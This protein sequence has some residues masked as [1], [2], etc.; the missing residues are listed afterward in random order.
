MQNEK[1]TQNLTNNFRFTWRTQKFLRLSFNFIFCRRRRL[2][3]TRILFSSLNLKMG[4]LSTSITSIRKKKLYCS[5]LILHHVQLFTVCIFL[6]TAIK[7]KTSTTYDIYWWKRPCP[8]FSILN[9][10]NWKNTT[11]TKV[12]IV[13]R[14]NMTYICRCAQNYVLWILR[15]FQIILFFFFGRIAILA[16]VMVLVFSTFFV[17]VLLCNFSKVIQTNPVHNIE[18]TVWTLDGI[19]FII[20]FRW[21]LN[22]ITFVN[23]LR[24]FRLWN[25]IC[26]SRFQW[27]TTEEK[28]ISLKFIVRCHTIEVI[29]VIWF[30]HTFDKHLYMHIEAIF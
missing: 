29:H 1:K 26:I 10:I 22:S 5:S 21:I 19:G 13:C 2:S 18:F 8:K 24:P 7:K 9:W 11:T 12:Y 15:S 25:M 27:D 28:S 17:F 3:Y 16:I 14:W 20:I 30:W 23:G 6:S 4:F